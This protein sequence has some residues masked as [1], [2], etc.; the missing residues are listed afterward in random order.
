MLLSNVSGSMAARKATL[1][2]DMKKEGE[3]VIS[4]NIIVL[5]DG[6]PV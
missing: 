1:E 4:Q 5:D 6:R 3:R 2:I